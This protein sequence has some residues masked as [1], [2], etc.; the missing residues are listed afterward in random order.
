MLQ[1]LQLQRYPASDTEGFRF[2]FNDRR[3]TDSQ[4]HPLRRRL[5]VNAVRMFV[6]LH[7]TIIAQA[8]QR[9][10]IGEGY[11]VARQSGRASGLA[12]R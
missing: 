1:Q 8:A 5:D 2:Q 6:P 12:R 10:S 4:P 3:P 7:P 9:V 11:S